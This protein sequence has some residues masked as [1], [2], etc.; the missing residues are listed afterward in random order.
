LTEL[1]QYVK[2]FHTTG[3]TWNPKGGDAKSAV[4]GKS[5]PTSSAPTPGP[6]S[7]GAPPPPPAP[8]A[9]QLEA[10]SAKETSKSAG[11]A[12]FLG[13]LSKGTTGLR[14]VEKSEMTHK[15]PEL[16]AG[17]VVKATEKP[18][19]A[20]RGGNAPKGPP[21]LA[22]EGNKWVVENHFNNNEVVI[23]Q[24]EIRHVVYIYN[25]QNSTIKITGKV[26]AVTIGI[27]D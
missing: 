21:K 3:L 17:S 24:T 9:A 19:S 13:E 23:D 22:L 2:K 20:P 4:V 14:K 5:T 12:S 7:A 15:N 27:C 8:T 18:I 11:G 25:C 6:G 16:R 10:F 1:F 26:N